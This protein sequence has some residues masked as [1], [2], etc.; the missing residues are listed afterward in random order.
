MG[1][2]RL[3]IALGVLSQKHGLGTANTAIA[4]H[5][6]KMSEGWGWGCWSRGGQA[7]QGTHGLGTAKHRRCVPRWQ[8]GRRSGWWGGMGGPF[9]DV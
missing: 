1:L 9:N 2:N 5:A 4:Y 8:G 3:A 6:G 7:A